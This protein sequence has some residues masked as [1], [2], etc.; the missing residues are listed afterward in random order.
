MKKLLI[1]LI[2]LAFAFSFANA[3][4]FQE[5]LQ[6]LAAEN[7]QGYLKPFPTAFG[8]NMNSGLFHTAKTHKPFLGFDV[9]VKVMFAFVPDEDMTYDFQLPTTPI[10]FDYMGQ[11]VSLTPADIYS[12]TE[13]PTVFGE[14]KEE[15]AADPVLVADALAAQGI[16]G[17]SVAQIQ[18]LINDYLII[19]IPPGFDIPGLPLMIPQVSVGLPMKSEILLR[20]YPKTKVSD[21]LGEFGFFGIGVK[22][23]I[24]Q[25]IP[26]FP[27]NL[28]AQFA[29]QSLNFGDII[30]SKHMSLGVVASKGLILFTPYV[31]VNYESSSLSVD[32]TVN[33]EDPND[34]FYEDY[35]GTQVSFDMDGDNSFHMRAGVYF[36][37]LI[38]GI[39][40]E[41]AMGKYNAAT[42]GAC[43]SFL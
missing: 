7:A 37:L 27:I 25:Y 5:E 41:Y 11:T 24:S 38:I 35:N 40:A 8:T 29:Y 42:V 31:G 15:L 9:G 20:F 39:N 34:P 26:L 2:V 16:T 19:D 21:D 10:T 36:R 23:S 17:L 28:S 30:E 32:Y 18:Q 3:Q 4:S 6:K 1:V 22:H 33:I 43:I 14:D 12:D 13:A